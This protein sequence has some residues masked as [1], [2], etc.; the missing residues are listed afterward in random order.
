MASDTGVHDDRDADVAIVGC[1]PTG[2]VAAILLGQAGHRVTV[3]ERWPAPYP[4]P[5]A[6]H[7]DGEIGRV[8]QSCGIG[9]DLRR[10]IEPADVYEW[11][12]GAGVTLL[13]FGLIGDSATGWP[14]A[15]MFCQPELEALLERRARQLPSVEIRRG[16]E[17]ERLS[18]TDDRVV[19]E[20]ASGDVVSARYVIGADGARSTVR[21]LLGIEMVDLGYFYDWFVVDVVLDEPR[22]YDPVN[23]QVCDPARPTTLVSGG[24]G[25]RRWEFMRL[26]DEDPAT[27]N[28]EAHAWELLA[29]WDVT[30]ANAR[31]ERH[32]DYRFHARY[33]ERWHDG[34]VFLAG[35][36]AHLT[37]PFAGQGLCAGARDAANLAWKLD[38][39]LAG[40]AHPSL[41]QSYDVERIEPAKQVIEFAM[42]LG[43]IICVPDPEEAAA[44]DAAMAATVS[45]EL[46]P[47]I[48]M[49]GITAGCIAAGSPHAGQRFVQGWVDGRPFDDV[50][51]AGW[52]LV[53]S[54]ASAETADVAADVRAWFE[55]I[56]G[57][58]VTVA[59]DGEDDTHRRWFAEHGC[60]WALQRPDFHLYGTATTA[61]AAAELLERLREHLRTA[62][63]AVTV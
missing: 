6:V 17:V 8:L 20:C 58:V 28:T 48:G 44:R 14:S 41:L 21:S 45:D 15:S 36:A 60:T 3:L 4:L 35:D 19:L 63:P 46:T 25:R 30:P 37:P 31:L 59:T 13:R 33:A 2:L 52:R 16:V 24:P 27:F 26:P 18:Q 50:H 40:R 56:G 29:P 57:R 43:R 1:G 7:F 9:D 32:A 51:G 61:T 54:G 47:A 22:V 12:N 53:G 11:R 5:R 49:P 10:I 55:S 34:R 39:V 38:L 62:A 23:L 42:E